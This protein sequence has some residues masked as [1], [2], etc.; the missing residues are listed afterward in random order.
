MKAF[1][2]GRG[3]KKSGHCDPLRDWFLFIRASLLVFLLVGE[4]PISAEKRFIQKR[5]THPLGD[6]NKLVVIGVLG[7]QQERVLLGHVRLYVFFVFFKN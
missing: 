4:I 1:C 7:G 3:R 6:H 5:E 2:K